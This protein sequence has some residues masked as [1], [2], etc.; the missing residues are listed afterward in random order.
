MVN[1]IVSVTDTLSN[2]NDQMAN[3]A[4]LIGRSKDRQK[5]FEAIYRGK[6]QIK[7]TNTLANRLD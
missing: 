7:T 1:S 3:A 5:V 6:K 2:I 4:R